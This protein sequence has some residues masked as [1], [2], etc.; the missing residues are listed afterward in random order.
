MFGY[1]VVLTGLFHHTSVG[2][3]VWKS[4]QEGKLTLR[5]SAV[6][7]VWLGPACLLSGRMP[8]S[9]LFIGD[10][11]REKVLSE[12][13]RRLKFLSVFCS[14]N[15]KLDPQTSDECI[16]VPNMFR[17]YAHAVNKISK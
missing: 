1:G 14:K 8:T 17:S 6:Q 13:Q 4:S 16:C 2:N 12:H 10:K 5:L 3:F 9:A 7:C 15:E 11:E